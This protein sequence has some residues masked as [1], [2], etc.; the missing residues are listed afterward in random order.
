MAKAIGQS[1]QTVKNWEDRPTG[2]SQGGAIK[3]QS[4]TGISA[5]WILEGVRPALLEKGLP[6]Q[7]GGRDMGK[8][9]H[10]VELLRWAAEIRARVGLAPFTAAKEA[11]LLESVYDLL[12]QP[13]P[14]NSYEINAWLNKEA[15]GGESVGQD[16]DRSD[17]EHGVGGARRKAS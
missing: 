2:V 1:S 9:A 6:S 12:T 15:T 4:L 7:P 17:Q 3:A 11:E 8:M 10:A 14:T 5:T 16:E 13:E